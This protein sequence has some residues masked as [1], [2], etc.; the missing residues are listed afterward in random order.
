MKPLKAWHTTHYQRCCDLTPLDDSQIYQISPRVFQF[1]DIRACSVVFYAKRIVKLFFVRQIPLEKPVSESRVLKLIFPLNI[2]PSMLTLIPSSRE[3]LALIH[4]IF[5]QR[6]FSTLFQFGLE[7]CTVVTVLYVPVKKYSF[8]L[9]RSHR[10]SEFSSLCW[11]LSFW[12]PAATLISRGF[13]QDNPRA[14]HVQTQTQQNEWMG[15]GK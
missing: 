13:Q 3:S 11:W 6:F 15:P 7:L 8:V 14:D 10:V 5:L 1:A 12:R 4:E 2:K 9:F